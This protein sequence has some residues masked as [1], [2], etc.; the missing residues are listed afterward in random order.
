MG[1]VGSNQ[2]PDLQQDITALYGCVKTEDDI[3]KAIKLLLAS[4]TLDEKIGQMKQYSYDG[5]TLDPD[6]EVL[7]ARGEVGSVLFARSVT[8][9]NAMQQ[10]AMEK[11]RL[12]IPIIVGRDVIH[13]YRTIMPIPLAQAA[14]FNADLVERAARI[15]AIEAT[16]SGARWTFSPMIDIARDPRWGRIA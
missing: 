2:K 7:I 13:G 1:G 15:A 4:M 16:T 8:V 11:S 5:K 9:V 10:A 14:S 12:K 6:F 3:E